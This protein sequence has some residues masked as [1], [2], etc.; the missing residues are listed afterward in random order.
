MALTGSACCAEPETDRVRKQFNSDNYTVTWDSPRT[1]DASAELEISDGYGHGFTLGWLRFRPGKDHVDVLS[2]TLKEDKQ[3]YDTKWPLDRAPIVITRAQMKSDGYAALLRDLAVVDA[4]KLK[5]V[6]RNSAISTTN[7][8]CVYARLTSN[9]Q[10]LI[11][12]N[13]A[14]YEGS[15]AEVEFA[16]PKAA[17][18]LAREAIKGFSF[19]E[20]S[21]TKED[22]AW[23]SAKL[24]RDWKK[25]KDLDFHWWVR[26]RYL[27]TIGVVGDRA[28][29]PTMREILG[30][31]PKGRCVYYAINAVTRLIEKDV[32]EKPVEGMDVEKTWQKVLALIRDEK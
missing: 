29:L 31:D 1:F 32:R 19:T 15:T 2:I 21:L 23:A 9:K 5:P 4:A 17:V 10:A 24:T 28:V 30:G 27:I 22:R 26:E 12:L 25:F 7:D 18:V 20:Y 11:D 13:W 3:P 16:K 6:H 14:G 8:P